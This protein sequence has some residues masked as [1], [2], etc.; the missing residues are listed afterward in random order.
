V[1]SGIQKAMEPAVQ[2]REE[3]KAKA[4]EQFGAALEKAGIETQTEASH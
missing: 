3:E 4:S 2:R 1:E